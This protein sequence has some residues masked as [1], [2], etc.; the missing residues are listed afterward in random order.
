MNP[1][2]LRELFDRAVDLSPPQRT[3]FLDT[4][5]P[6]PVLRAQVERLLASDGQDGPGVSGS[7]ETLAAAIGEAHVPQWTPGLRVGSFTLVEPLGQGGFATVFHAVRENADV[8]QDVALKLLNRGLYSADA[9]RQFQR[10]RQALAQLRHGN[11]AHLIE[12]GITDTGQAYIALELVDGVA[13]TDYA[14]ARQLSLS[15]RLRLF[16]QICR[17]VEAAH[18][19]LIVHRDLKPSN[20]LVTMDGQVKLLDFGIAKLLEGETDATRTQMPAF[21]PAYAA[22]EQRDNGP[23]TTAT[24]VYALGVLLGELLTG[25]RLQCGGSDTPSGRIDAS[26]DPGVLPAAPALTRHLLRGDLDNIVLK[27][28]SEEPERRYASAGALAE[29]VER[30]LDRRPVLAHPPSRWYRTRRFV[31]RHRGGVL[32][33]TLLVVG[34]LASLGVAL[35]QARVAG[36]QAALAREQTLRAEAVR[37]FLVSVFESAQADLP[38]ERR[39]GIEDIVDDAGH[40]ILVDHDLGETARAELL[41]VLAQVNRN[42]AAHDRALTMLDSAQPLIDRLY[43]RADDRWWRA[44]FLR[45]SLLLEKAEFATALAAIEPLHA[46]LLLRRDVVSSEGLRLLAMALMYAS[47]FDELAAIYDQAREHAA[48]LGADAERERIRIDIAEAV[49]L[50]YMQRFRDGL[51][52]ADRTW[53]RWRALNALPDRHVQGLLRSTS[54]AAEAV[55]DMERAEA[56]YRDAIDLAER[57]YARPHPETAWAIGIYGSFLVARLRYD[58]AEPHLL[59][60]LEMRRNLLGDGHPDTLNGMAAMGRLRAGQHRN[61]E[62]LR[63]FADGVALCRRHGL[64]HNVCPRLLGSQANMLSIEDDTLDAA[65]AAATDAVAWQTRLTGADSPPVAAMQ[66]FLARV[67]VRQGRYREALATTDALLERFRHSG[68]GMSMDTVNARL[69]RALALFGL[70]RYDEA[71]A[72]ARA[73]GID[74][75]R[76]IGADSAMLFNI[77]TLQAR[78]LARLERRDEARAAAAGALAV[79][80]G[81]NPPP[82]ELAMRESLGRMA[83]TGRDD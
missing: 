74:Y 65:A 77:L 1:Q 70:G 62:A 39:P 8:R 34:I 27:A 58:E 40:R 60:A 12:A 78:A 35:W 26:A 81:P 54:V 38:R 50:I 43:G 68:G 46:D 33:T 52:L 44:H 41:L 49:G 79:A 14:R 24:D 48:L 56:A 55:G 17:A 66:Q 47:R 23:I 2:R 80:S 53:T 51:E 4:H 37:D 18:R 16:I 29:D 73:L 5:C 76:D 13:I 31:Q 82:R 83:R 69:Q 22:P 45:V 64:E 67:Q 63:W 6:D 72:E 42:L 57:L 25:V 71:L 19:A 9:K 20:V 75:R 11:I 36:M 28:M 7:A 30:Y 59:R 10:E 15:A 21:T 61:G 32:V 3:A